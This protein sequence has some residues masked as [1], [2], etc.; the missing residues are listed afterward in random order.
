ME[1]TINDQQTRLIPVGP[2]GIIA[3]KGSKEL[4]NMIDQ[5][6]H[7]ERERY[8]LSDPDMAQYPGFLRDTYLIDCDTPRF[9]SGEGKGIMRDTVRGYDIYIVVDVINFSCTYKAFGMESHMSPDD[10]YQDLKRV[11]A[12]I[13]G[14]ARRITV[15][16]P[17]LYE[18]R[19][20]KRSARESLDCAMALQELAAIGVDNIITFDAHDNRVANAVPLIGFENLMPTYQMIKALVNSCDNIEIDRDKMI[21][22]SPDEG[23]MSRC[24]Y[25]SSM[26][27]VNVGMFYK[28][29][30]YTRVVNGRNPIVSHEYLGESVE[31]KDIIVVD[32]MLSSGDSM[33]DIARELKARKAGRIFLAATFGLFTEGL[34]AFDKYYA[35]GLIDKVLCTNLSYRRPELLERPW[36]LDVDMSRYLS[37]IVDTL[38]HDGSISPLLNPGIKIQSLVNAHK[39]KQ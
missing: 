34:E 33:L 36:Y 19:Q 37:L 26:L 15:V 22:I 12:S 11:I 7:A 18:S 23:A 17:F 25:F 5:A 8:L 30:D 24:L 32:D 9:A 31:G 14:K 2:L 10:H 16:M 35:D 6:I 3:T 20:H 1:R 27:G 28:R 13:G 4:G 39:N 29:R 21:I 38:N